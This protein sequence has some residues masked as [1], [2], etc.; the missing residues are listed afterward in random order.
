MPLPEL[1]GR[2]RPVR[3][4]GAGGFAVVW[5]AHDE[6]LDAEVAVKVMADNWADRLDLRERF[7]REARMLRQA[8]SQR[9]VQVFDIGE[10]ADD[11]PYLVMEYADRGTLADRVKADGAYPLAEAL[12]VTAEVARGVAELHSAGVVHR[13]LKPSNVLITSVRGGGERLLVADLGVAKSLAHGSGVTMSVGSAGYMAPEQMEPQIGV[14]PRADVYSLGAFAYHLMTA[15]KPPISLVLREKLPSDLPP[16]VRETLLLTLL[17]DREN[18]WPDAASLAA[19]FDEL[20]S[21]I[22]DDVTVAA[23]PTRGHGGSGFTPTPG[24]FTPGGTGGSAFPQPVSPTPGWNYQ[25]TPDPQ[26]ARTG[27]GWQNYQGSPTG[28]GQFT[29][30]PPSG[31]QPA[32]QDSYR[33]SYANAPSNTPHRTPDSQGWSQS[34]YAQTPQ[35]AGQQY[36]QPQQTPSPLQGFQPAQAATQ[37]PSTTPA[38]PLGR[39]H[40]RWIATMTAVVVLA[41]ATGIGAVLLW[42]WRAGRDLTVTDASGSITLTAPPVFG[43]ELVKSGWNPTTIGLT[44]TK[45]DGLLLSD[46]VEDWSDLTQNINGVFVGL[47]DSKNLPKKV[48]AITHDKC[49]DGKAKPF[50]VSSGWTGEIHTWTDCETGTGQVQEAYLEPQEGSSTY[51]YMQIRRT[52]DNDHSPEQLIDQLVVSEGS[53][54]RN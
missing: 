30:Q 49:T 34:G 21:H 5:L 33:G 11:R 39:G 24:S 38:R 3:R 46:R 7:L 50:E 17:S 20:A 48:K 26:S 52:G 27:T 18:R 54:T 16:A 47:S 2:Y 42:Q 45:A 9:I 36:N 25:G 22:D 6:S 31:R 43:S 1:I 40:G 29:Q 23:I 37:R 44:A 35:G 51:V 28:P 12:R 41:A 10:L 4:L 15:E 8:A 53:A 19:R 14:D 13:D 32:P